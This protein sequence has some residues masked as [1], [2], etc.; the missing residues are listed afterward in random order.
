MPRDTR[1]QQLLEKVV[2]PQALSTCWH[3]MQSSGVSSCDEDDDDWAM[4]PAPFHQNAFNDGDDEEA[5]YAEAL[6][7]ELLRVSPAFT[8]SILLP[9]LEQ[10][11]S[12]TQ[13]QQQ[14]N[15]NINNSWKVHRAALAA[16]QCCVEA[17]PVSF[18]PHVAHATQAALRAAACSDNNNNNSPRVQYQAVRLIGVLCET[19]TAPSVRD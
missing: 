1:Q 11:F 17:I 4:E 5:D 7:A 15:S 6:L 18:A 2:L 10:A 14:D 19:T 9:V 16:L 8:L 12:S 13:H 3:A